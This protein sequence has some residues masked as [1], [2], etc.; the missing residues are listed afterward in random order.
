MSKIIEIGRYVIPEGC[1]I[2]VFGKEFIIREKK[3]Q[4]L[5]KNDKRCRDCKFN[6]F[7]KSEYHNN[8]RPKKICI[9]HPKNYNNAKG[10]ALYYACNPYHVI[11]DKFEPIDMEEEI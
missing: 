11:C 4:R 10:E 1:V 8:G 7:G 9:K 5:D 6:V 2:D 3:S